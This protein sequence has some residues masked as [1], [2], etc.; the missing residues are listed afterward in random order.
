MSPTRPF[1]RLARLA[2]LP[3]LL[4]LAACGAP[5]PTAATH[6][7][8]GSWHGTFLFSPSAPGAVSH[9]GTVAMSVQ[10]D[11]RMAGTVWL[12]DAAESGKLAGTLDRGGALAGTLDQFRVQGQLRITAAGRASGTGTQLLDDTAVGTIA[13]EMQRS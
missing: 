9:A 1:R 5:G 10:D 4:A 13:V 11:G 12:D 3:V 8:A 2:A 7:F 6:P